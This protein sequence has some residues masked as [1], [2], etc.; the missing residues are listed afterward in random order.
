[1]KSYG[2]GM[3]V[4]TELVVWFGLGCRVDVDEC[5]SACMKHWTRVNVDDAYNPQHTQPYN[6][7]V[8]GLLW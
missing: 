1:M 3:C 6:G 2:I 4:Y 7:E 8:D 5:Q